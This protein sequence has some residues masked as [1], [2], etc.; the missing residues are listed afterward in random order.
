[1]FTLVFLT[2]LNQG[3]LRQEIQQRYNASRPQSTVSNQTV[4]LEVSTVYIKTISAINA[5]SNN[6][7]S[8]ELKTKSCIQD[9]LQLHV[10]GYNSF[11]WI[12]YLYVMYTRNTVNTPY[13]RNGTSIF[14]WF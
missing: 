11:V 8:S 9:T 7:I 4:R 13:M 1:M 6:T 10:R 14:K 12:E 2:D 5:N 3:S